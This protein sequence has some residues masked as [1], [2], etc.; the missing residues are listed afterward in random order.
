MNKYFDYFVIIQKN[1]FWGF[2][3][4]FYIM[5]CTIRIVYR[6]DQNL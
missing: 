3:P 6:N 2:E 5:N 1:N 4:Y